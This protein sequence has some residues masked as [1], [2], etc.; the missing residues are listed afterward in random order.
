MIWFFN[1][2]FR[3]WQ[4][5]PLQWS[6]PLGRLSAEYFVTNGSFISILFHFLFLSTRLFI[7][8]YFHTLN[9]LS[10]L[11][12]LFV[13]SC[14]LLSSFT[15]SLTSFN[16]FIIVLLISVS[17]SFIYCSPMENCCGICN[18]W[19]RN[20]IFQS[21]FPVLAFALLRWSGIRS[22]TELL[23]SSFSIQF[24]LLLSVELLAMLEMLYR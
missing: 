12:K 18:F 9:W 8:F 11:I 22:L 1:L 10:Y 13:F 21:M 3:L 2:A 19:R 5:C 6:I 24:S 7:K 15:S 4:L 16:T 14:N 17:K 23:F 20:M